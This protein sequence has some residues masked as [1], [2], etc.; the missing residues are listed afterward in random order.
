MKTQ[1]VQTDSESSTQTASLGVQPLD[2][3]TLAD[4][5]TSQLLSVQ[6]GILLNLPLLRSVVTFSVDGTAQQT[7]H[8]CCCP[9]A[10]GWN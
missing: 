9:K 3:Q 4:L 6:V 10:G 5:V 8:L 7:V 2:M 1:E